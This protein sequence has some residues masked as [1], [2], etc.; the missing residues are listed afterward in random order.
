MSTPSDFYKEIAADYDRMTRLAGR[1]DAEER[2]LGR[3]KKRFGFKSALDA[4]CGTGLHAIALARLGVATVAAD[5]SAEML[6]VARRNAQ[7]E[8]ARLEFLETSMTRLAARLQGPFDAI[9]CLGNSL[10]HLERDGDLEAAL[11]GF[12]RLLDPDGVVVL[13]LLNYAK[14]L[15]TRERVIAINADGDSQYVRFY[16]FLDDRVR[17]NVLTIR[18]SGSKFSHSLSSTILRPYT[19]QELQLALQATGFGR[20]EV[21]GDMSFAPF[22]A[23]A[24]PNVVIGARR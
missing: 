12:A 4:A 3:W 8:G 22:K 18:R 9:F 14:I 24:A 15:K 11:S 13:Q 2:T 20:L 5:I 17:F 19:L 21:F 1:L 23:D 10:P 16:D 7:N 6:D